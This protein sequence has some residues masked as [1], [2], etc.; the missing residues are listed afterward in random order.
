MPVARNANLA[1]SAPDTAGTAILVLDMI[2]DF[3]F[4]DGERVLR[5]AKPVAARIARLKRRAEAAGTPVIYVND[6]RGRWRADFPGLLRHALGT[7]SRGAPI[8]RQL[9]PGTGDYCILKPKH[10]GFFGTVLDTL[11]EH[12][13]VRRLVIT[14]VSAHQCVLFTA[15]DAY[16]RDLE[17]CIP[18][19]CIAAEA[20]ARTRFALRYFREVLAADLAPSPKVRLARVR[21]AGRARAAHR[22]AGR[23][24]GGRG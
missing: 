3:G 20:P 21:R 15:N 9:V 4:E 6:N 2:S 14:G 11:L 24:A 18:R 23:R 19:D 8:A 5:A 17:L 10:S 1:G 16:V 13:G 7:G 22:P 12:L